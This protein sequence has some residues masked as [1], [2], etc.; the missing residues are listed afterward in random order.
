LF[1]NKPYLK[2][3]LLLT[4]IF[5]IKAIDNINIFDGHAMFFKIEFYFIV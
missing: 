3:K 4:C 1:L 2:E 5:K